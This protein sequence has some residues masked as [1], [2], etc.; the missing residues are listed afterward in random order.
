[1]SWDLAELWSNEIK[2]PKFPVTER[3]IKVTPSGMRVLRLAYILSCELKIIECFMNF[4]VG[5]NITW[6]DL[7]FFFF[8]VYLYV[9]SSKIAV[10][11][12]LFVIVSSPLFINFHS[13]TFIM[14]YFFN[15][16]Y[17]LNIW[18]IGVITNLFGTD[19][20]AII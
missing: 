7:V 2:K 13:F 18:D 12:F 10:R 5:L 16:V 9:R 4:V 15:T 19:T 11:L 1:M 8:L 20:C 17:T 6:D 14:I 3:S